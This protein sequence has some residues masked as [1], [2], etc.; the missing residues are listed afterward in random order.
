MYTRPY[1]LR[2]IEQVVVYLYAL[3]PLSLRLFARSDFMM[4]FHLQQNSLPA[5]NYSVAYLEDLSVS[6]GML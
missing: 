4:S 5:R 1:Q 2:G 3:L 6:A